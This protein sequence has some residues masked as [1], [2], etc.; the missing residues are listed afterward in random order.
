M[1]MFMLV[2]V[3]ML[4]TATHLNEGKKKALAT[5]LILRQNHTWRCRQWDEQAS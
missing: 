5:R 1:F 2:L 4:M 3:L